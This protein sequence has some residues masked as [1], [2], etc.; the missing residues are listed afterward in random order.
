MKQYATADIRN[1]SLVGHGA[2]GKT[3]LSEAMLY[4]NGQINR[5]GTI[6]AGNTVSDYHPG[7]QKRQI[8]IHSTPMVTEWNDKKFN[9]IDTPGYS[10]FIGEALSSLAVVD[11]AVVV[12]SAVNGVEVG[13]EQVWD[14]ATRN[15]IPKIIVINGLDR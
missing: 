5:M 10:D 1:F 3:C 2:S 4:C 12:L 6:D 14:H 15:V 9:L 7:E 8:S 13:T 11:M